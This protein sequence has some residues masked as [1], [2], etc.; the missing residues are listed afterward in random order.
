MRSTS[1]IVNGRS[2]RASTIENTE[3]FAPRPRASVTMMMAL[4]EGRLTIAR[5]AYRVSRPIVR[6]RESPHAGEGGEY[7]RDR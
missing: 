1:R 3:A 4:V 5:N 7:C 6:M 2:T